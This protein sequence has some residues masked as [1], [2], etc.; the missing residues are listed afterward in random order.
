MAISKAPDEQRS[1]LDLGADP[2]ALP[3]AGVPQEEYVQVASA[4]SALTSKLARSRTKEIIGGLTAPGA[5]LSPE[6]RVTPQAG[7]MPVVTDVPLGPRLEI[8]AAETPQPQ[9]KS[10]PPVSQE[11]V[12]ARMQAREAEMGTREVPSPSKKQIAEGIQEGPVNTRFY[13]S[14]SF[15]ATVQ[16]AAKA[17]DEGIVAAKKPMSIKEIYDRATEA[18]I[19]KENLDKIFSGQGIDASIG[20]N[21]LATR[22]A[23]L[24]VLHD[25]SAGKVDDL[26]RLAAR[27]ELDEPGKLALREAMAQHDMILAQLSGAKTD[28][29]R[30]MNVF[31]GASDRPNGLT[32]KELR[33]ALNELGGDDQLMRLA[34][35]YVKAPSKAARNKLLRNSVK[36]KAYESIVYMAQSVMLNEPSTHIFN[37]LGNV[38]F[39][40]LD[41][42]ERAGAVAWGTLRQRLA[43]TFGYKTD[44]DRYYGADLYAR[45]SGFRNGIIDGVSMMG[46]KFSEG[47]A[48]KDVSRDPIRTEHWA[49]A[50]YKIPFT[51]D[52]REFPDLTNT[53]FG[54]LVNGLGLVYSVPFRALGAADE[55]FA[56]VAQRVQLHEEAARAGGKVFDNTLADLTSRGVDPRVAQQEATQVAANHVQKFLTEMPGEIDMSI[57]A[58]RKQVTLQADIDKELPLAGLYNGANK[59]FNKWYLKPMVPFSKT[60]TNIANEGNARIG[61]LN[62][63]SPAFYAEWQKGGRHKDLAISRVMLG[64]GLAMSGYWL[65]GEGRV[66]GSGP[67]DT[68]YRNM[69]KSNGWQPFAYRIGKDE[70]S[71]AN[72]KQLRQ[73]LGQENV[74]EGAGKDFGDSYFISLKR[75]EPV[76]MPFM[77]GAAMADVARFG[78]YDEDSSVFE[79]MFYAASAGLAETTTNMPAMQGISELT[80]IVGYKQ[81]DTGDRLVSV[82]NALQKRYTSFLIS[83]T[84]VVGFANS[85]MTARLERLLDPEVSN[86]GVGDEYPAALVGFGEAYNRFK[87]RVPFWS[88]AVP[89]KLND[90]GDPVGLENTNIAYPISMTKGETDNVK[91]FMDAIHMGP[92][93]FPKK[94]EGI[95]VPPE[96]ENRWKLLANKEIL[97][98]GMTLSE[99]IEASMTEFMDDYEMTG[100][101]LP[102]GDMRALIKKI[103]NT[104]RNLAKARLF[105][106]LTE[107][108]IT[109]E[110]QYSQIPVDMFDYGLSDQ[111]VEFPEFAEKLADVKNKKRFPKLTE[112]TKKETPS[113]TGMIK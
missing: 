2:N 66:T 88:R 93:P 18:G 107:D 58:W 86:V 33:D 68:S 77:F 84:P 94:V 59:L 25:V 49:G 78:D 12:D 46:R 9:P 65:A 108:P 79:N 87:S 72:V 92:T 85:T 74:T 1:V 37:A 71:S 98:D 26:M 89:I 61:V 30:S 8:P 5:R 15:A 11:Q 55:F 97:I 22:M 96:I 36:R 6:M 102:I 10:P 40:F 57:N 101:E 104:Y 39:S 52:I 51:R 105:G 19:P 112:P 16:A 60:M 81:R 95:K 76:N 91:E 53:A 63:M 43:K 75:L 109:G 73:I 99:N 82:F 44:P 41:V 113:L 34:E 106:E 90:F 31:K 3:D 54:K 70:I 50:A 14:D 83:G 100:D 67:G 23:G 38:L 45:L 4:T 21:E 20:G 13:D 103:Q 7:E 69:L 56:G 48:A 47:G 35:E 24:M 111:V 27:G 28:I 32:Q 29:A 62:F 42:P 64:S 80:S 17:A 110:A